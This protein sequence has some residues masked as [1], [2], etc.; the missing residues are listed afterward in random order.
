MSTIFAKIIAKEI[1]AKILHE[2][3]KCLAFSDINPQAPVHFLVIPKKEIKTLAE[4]E[5]TDGELLGHLLLKCRQIAKE[6]GLEEG[7]RVVLNVGPNGGQEV[8]HIHF[9][10][11]GKRQMKW[12]PG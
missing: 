5:D 7:Y 11:M 10:V 1:P 9:H 8:Y 6:Q 4:A 12:P 2:D 3:E